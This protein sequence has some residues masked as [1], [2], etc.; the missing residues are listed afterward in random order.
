MNELDG[1]RRANSATEAAVCLDSEPLTQF[2]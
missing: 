1:F 2:S